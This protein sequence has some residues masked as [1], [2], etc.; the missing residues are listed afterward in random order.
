MATRY[1]AVHQTLNGP[2]D[3]RPTALQIIRDEQLSGKWSDKTVLITGCSSGIGIETAKALHETGATIYATARDLNKAKSALSSIID[4]DRVYL[5]ELDLESL[6]SVRNCAETFLAKSDRLD[7]LI[8]NAGVMATPEG[9]TADGFETQF[10]TNHLAHFLLIQLLL[11][12][13]EK[14]SKPNSQSRVV[15]LS[16]VAHRNGEVNFPNLNFDGEY[17]AWKAYA[18][19]KTANLWASNEVERRFGP[20]GVHS[21]SVHPGGIMT[22]LMQHFSDEHKQALGTNPGVLALLKSPEQ[23]AATTVW[24]AT[25]KVHEGQGG[26]YL[27]DCQ[28]AKPPK[29]GAAQF[30]PGYSAW[31]YDEK[32]AIL[33]WER[34]LELVKPFLG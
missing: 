15:V 5:L 19:S 23:G 7:V 26:K 1:E 3:A 11:P 34:S 8:T 28:I 14:S 9:R 4:S 21:L 33:L 31:A 20:K 32:K 18:Q 24:A 2:G 27:E 12:I 10:G 30:D 29:D 6:A 25:A 16:S 22:G 17:D 13:L